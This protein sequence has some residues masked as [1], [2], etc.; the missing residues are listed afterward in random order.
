MSRRI[1]LLLAALMFAATAT[2]LTQRW[3]DVRLA[4]DASAAPEP[5]IDVLVAAYALE[6]GTVIAPTMLRWARWPAEGSRGLIVAGKV[7]AEGFN[8]AIVRS[9]MI[10]G[11]PVTLARLVHPGTRGPMAATIAPGA[12]AVT[13]SVT[14]ASGMAGFALP[15]DRVDLLLTQTLTASDG[16]AE[17]HLS[18][19]VLHN[20]RVLGTDQRGSGSNDAAQSALDAST[21]ASLLGSH[22][23]AAPP[24]STVTLEVSP[25]GAELIAVA[26]ELGKLSLSLRSLVAGAPASGGATW[27]VDATHILPRAT[28]APASQQMAVAPIATV[29]TFVPSRTSPTIVRG[30]GT[31]SVETTK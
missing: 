13:I 21:D 22:A 7:R 17:R 1:L 28:V 9:A 8:G 5:A 6:V 27:D 25:K 16:R 24:P 14:P 15:G 20:V 11:E 23:N 29:A 3:L 30:T 12:R 2:L 10:E 19:T 31:A 26:V 18:Q 4:G